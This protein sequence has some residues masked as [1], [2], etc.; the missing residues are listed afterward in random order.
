MTKRI[1]IMVGVAA[2]I[3]TTMCYMA[4][5]AELSHAHIG[6]ASGFGP[7][8]PH[9]LTPHIGRLYFTPGDGSHNTE[10]VTELSKHHPTRAQAVCARNRVEY[11]TRHGIDTPRPLEGFSGCQK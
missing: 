9:P 6:F 2:L 11:F 4:L 3:G 5:E 1:L 7:H 10:R 8:A